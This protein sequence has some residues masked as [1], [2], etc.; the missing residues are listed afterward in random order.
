M[1]SKTLT[2]KELA[3][4]GWSRCTNCGAIRSPYTGLDFHNHATE[5]CIYS[6]ESGFIVNKKKIH[7]AKPLTATQILKTLNL[8]EKDIEEVKITLEKTK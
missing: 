7:I 5:D 8:T 3:N 4:K 2:D 6:T 1:I